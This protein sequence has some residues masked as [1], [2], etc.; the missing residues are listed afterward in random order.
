M[1]HYTHIKIWKD[2]N[3]K[4]QV[5]SM[6]LES[7][8]HIF[9][10]QTNPQSLLRVLDMDRGQQKSQGTAMISASLFCP[11][12]QQFGVES[13]KATQS[14]QGEAGETCNTHIRSGQTPLI[15]VYPQL[16]HCCGDE[17]DIYESA[18]PG[19]YCCAWSMWQPIMEMWGEC[20]EMLSN[21]KGI[22][23]R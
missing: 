19:H 13:G 10:E 3:A 11:L 15:R 16:H 17:Q 12:E 6:P 8:N 18:Y 20:K 5:Y 2:L 22:G 1:H 21:E 4:S 7:R 9:V 14:T 23:F